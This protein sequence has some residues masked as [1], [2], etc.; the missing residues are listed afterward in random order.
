MQYNVI[1]DIPGTDP[2]IG[3]QVVML[4]AHYDSWHAGT[5]ATD[6]GSGSAVMMEA[7]RLLTKLI[8]ESGEKPRRTIRIGL[9]SGEE[10]GLI[11]SRAYVSQHF[12]E[13]AGRGQPPASFKPGH[14]TFSGYFNL[15]N[16]TGKVRGASVSVR[17]VPFSGIPCIFLP[18][19]TWWGPAGCH[20][21][22]EP[23]LQR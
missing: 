2:V 8:D 6:N 11:G 19:L 13:S 17:S 5:G 9:W 4:G 12:A 1:A 14:K 10:Q 23:G 3:D 16:G 22:L 7:M 20:I 18:V 21:Q 15:D